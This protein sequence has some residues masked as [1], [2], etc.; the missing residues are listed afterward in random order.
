MSKS[1]YSTKISL[2]TQCVPL[3]VALVALVL[4]TKKSLMKKKLKITAHHI[5]IATLFTVLVKFME[6]WWMIWIVTE[7]C[8]SLSIYSPPSWDLIEESCGRP[9]ACKKLRKWCWWWPFLLKPPQT[10]PFK[11]FSF[12]AF[13]MLLLSGLELATC[14]KKS[15]NSCCSNYIYS[16]VY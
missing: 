16:T 12:L 14:A 3:A 6:R 7:D 13:L 5:P 8:F 15:P 11:N 10:P 9:R 1:N 4:S 2:L